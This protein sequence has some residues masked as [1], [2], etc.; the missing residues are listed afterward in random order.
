[1]KFFRNSLSVLLF[2]VVFFLLSPSPVVRAQQM[3]DSQRQTL[4]TQI[5]QQIVELQQQLSQILA[6]QQGSTGLP[7]RFK[8]PSINV[9]VPVEYVGL[10]SDG[11]MDVPKGPVN[12][13]WF[14]LGPRP[15]Q[16]GSSV[17]AGHSGWKD[18]IPAVFDNLHKLRKGDEIYIEDEKGANIIFVVR[19]IKIYGRNDNASD[20]F[21][22]SDGASH[23]NLITCTGV[24][25]KVEKTSSDRLVVFADKE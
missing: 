6:Q 16:N 2:V 13:G 22:S 14:N 5:Q 21:G 11:A 23:L 15:G 19:E 20:V 1:M 7:I 18:A 10:T 24:W 8:I 3:T 25:N 17:I 9:D 4:I 12:V